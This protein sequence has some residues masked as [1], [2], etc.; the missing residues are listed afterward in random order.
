[1]PELL[2]V[3]LLA[4]LPA[5]GNIAGATLAELTPVSDQWLN[6]ALH[7]AAGVV[8]AIVAIEI[9]PEALDS[10]AGWVLG[11]AFAIGGALYLLAETAVE[12]LAGDGDARPWMI[13]LAVATDLFGDGLLIG[14]GTAVSPGLGLTLAVGQVLADV[15]EGF[16]VASTFRANGIAPRTRRWLTASFVVP[17]VVAAALA[18]MFLR[19]RPDSWQWTTL[20]AAAGLFTV[21]VFED[22]IAEAHEA[23]E[24]RRAST[25]SLVAGFALF[26]FVSSGLGG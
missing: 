14:A 22:I 8:I 19:G 15:P 16:A 5:G 26:T 17:V 10:V 2:T 13:Y 9:F 25:V 21:A 18:F 12:R 3:L 1:V 20:T 23:A 11:T 4:L 24:D 7:A 6:R